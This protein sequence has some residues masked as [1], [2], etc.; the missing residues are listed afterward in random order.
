MNFPITDELNWE[1]I[2]HGRIYNVPLKGPNPRGMSAYCDRRVFCDHGY[3]V[4]GCGTP[5]MRCVPLDP[6]DEMD[7]MRIERQ[8]REKRMDKYRFEMYT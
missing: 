2:P 3:K 1:E 4:I 8:E 7:Q 6:N 5:E